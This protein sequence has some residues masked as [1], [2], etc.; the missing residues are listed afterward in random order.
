MTMNPD[1]KNDDDL[2]RLQ[3]QMALI[4]ALEARNQAQFD[5]FVDEQDQ[6]DSLEPDER[7]LLNCK[8]DVQER[9]DRLFLDL[10]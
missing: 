7:E 10:E 6:W 1:P 2:E 9:V 8:A 5:S 3:H 4:E